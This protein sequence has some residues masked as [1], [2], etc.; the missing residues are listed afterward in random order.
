V[1]HWLAVPNEA[2]GIHVPT[3]T[4]FVTST[5]PLTGLLFNVKPVM[6]AVPLMSSAVP[7]AREPIPTLPDTS[8]PFVGAAVFAY[9]T[10]PIPTPPTIDNA[11][12]VVHVPIPTLPFVT[13]KLLC[14]VTVPMPTLPLLVS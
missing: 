11:F 2:K 10:D 8:N 7:G 5:L 1:T 13:T 6:R 9:V 14:G 4:L 12:P 3:P